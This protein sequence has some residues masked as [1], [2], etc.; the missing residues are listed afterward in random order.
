M[1]SPLQKLHERVLEISS[2]AEHIRRQVAGLNAQ[3]AELKHLAMCS[4]AMPGDFDVVLVFRSRRGERS[5]LRAEL[6]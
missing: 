4:G 1:T 5:G 3:E 2:T 6:R